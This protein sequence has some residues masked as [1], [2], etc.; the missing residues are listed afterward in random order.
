MCWRVPGQTSCVLSIIIQT[1]RSMQS[2]VKTTAAT[3]LCARGE[4]SMSELVLSAGISHPFA[5]TNSY[6]RRG[7]L[8]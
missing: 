7:H 4:E 3:A 1:W 8:E 2:A 6:E 5:L